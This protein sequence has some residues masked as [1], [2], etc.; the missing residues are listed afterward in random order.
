[1]NKTGKQT[2]IPPPGGPK[3]TKQTS[4]I[5]STCEMVRSAMKKIKQERREGVLG[6]TPL[7]VAWSRK[8]R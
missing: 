7:H 4:K 3:I 5:H 6:R 8:P 2:E 1:M